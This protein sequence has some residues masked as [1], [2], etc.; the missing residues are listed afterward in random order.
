MISNTLS[1][2][3]HN[4]FWRATT[5]FSLRVWT[6][7]WYQETAEHQGFLQIPKFC[8][9]SVWRLSKVTLSG[10][11]CQNEVQ[12]INGN[13]YEIILLFSMWLYCISVE[14]WT[15]F[16]YYWYMCHNSK[17]NGTRLEIDVG[18]LLPL[19]IDAKSDGDPSKRYTWN[20]FARQS[21]ISRGARAFSRWSPR[22]SRPGPG[23]P[24]P[25][26]GSLP[27]LWKI[28]R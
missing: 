4:F 7:F 24:H 23:C 15:Y 26:G 2:K 18:Q 9:N 10:G 3:K 16:T 12:K 19:W 17:K 25:G 5:F 20:R 21:P 28:L 11:S 22:K 13:Q 8:P 6:K 27:A 14:I 1:K